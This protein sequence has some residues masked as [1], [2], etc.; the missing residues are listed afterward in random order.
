[1]KLNFKNIIES[2]IGGIIAAI[3]V[4][5][6]TLIFPNT[7][8]KI[9]TYISGENNTYINT[10][11]GNFENSVDDELNIDDK[12]EKINPP[13]LN[14]NFDKTT[15]T[16]AEGFLW[17]L[18]TIIASYALILG[19]STFID[20]LENYRHEIV[21]D[22]SFFSNAG[23]VL[24]YFRLFIFILFILNHTF[25]QNQTCSKLASIGI[26][27]TLFPA[28]LTFLL[29]NFTQNF[30]F[31]KTMNFIIFLLLLIGLNYLGMFNIDLSIE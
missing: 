2:V 26:G 16:I 8:N 31:P 4:A 7:T 19:L 24:K 15:S 27:L 5:L 29:S 13:Q 17:G 6:F 23:S 14:S 22:S 25:S 30:R 21:G 11:K 20:P 1:M 10:E 12:S 18:I 3:I 28:L 9:N